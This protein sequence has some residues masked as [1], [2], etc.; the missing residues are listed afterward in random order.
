MFSCHVITKHRRYESYFVCS[1]SINTLNLHRRTA[2]TAKSFYTFT[3]SENHH[4]TPPLYAHSP[5]HRVQAEMV[6]HT[7][8]TREQQS[9]YVLA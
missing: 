3:N 5:R 9:C 2:S 1:N 8:N 4:S 7:L 6:I